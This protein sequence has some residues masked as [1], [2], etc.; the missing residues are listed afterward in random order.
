MDMDTWI[1]VTQK[2]KTIQQKPFQIRGRIK[3]EKQ[4]NEQIVKGINSICEF[5]RLLLHKQSW[6]MFELSS[7]DRKATVREHHKC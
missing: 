1:L 3:Y 7:N 4:P 6:D 2:R 5:D